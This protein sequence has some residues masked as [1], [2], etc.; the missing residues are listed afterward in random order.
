MQ[1]LIGD[2]ENN[3]SSGASFWVKNATNQ[4]ISLAIEFGYQAVIKLKQMAVQPVVQTVMQPVVQS[5]YDKGKIGEQEIETILK[6]NFKNVTNVA[7]SAKSGDM[8]LYINNYK[9]MIEVKN[10]VNTVSYLNVE[11]FKR[12]IVATSSLGG[13]FISLDSAIAKT[14]SNMSI[15]YENGIPCI[16]LVS[17]D[18]DII[19][20]CVKIL[21]SVIDSKMCNISQDDLITI[22]NNLCE[23]LDH[24]QKVYDISN[25]INKEILKIGNTLSMTEGNL[26]KILEKVRANVPVEILNID[27]VFTNNKYV[28]GYDQ[29]IKTHLGT[30]INKCPNNWKKQGVQPVKYINVNG[31][32]IKCMKAHPEIIFEL[33]AINSNDI[34]NRWNTI[35]SGQ[36][37]LDKNVSIIV[38]DNTIEWILT[39]I[40][41]I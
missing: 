7:S 39:I 33:T 16:Y 29:V 9:I 24:K 25:N 14:P 6:S 30:I 21:A 31:L 20:C 34:L 38:S 2:I 3:L 8:S 11:K 17:R 32:E 4:D 13:I 41:S 5:S 22:D 18:P 35:Q 12:D 10:Y 36:I 1:S 23:F 15:V 27:D 37:K 28:S 19:V 40:N 26:K